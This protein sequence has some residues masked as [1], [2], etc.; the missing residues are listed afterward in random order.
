MVVTPETWSSFLTVSPDPLLCAQRGPSI[1][2]YCLY[3]L[4][5]MPWLPSAPHCSASELLL[6]CPHTIPTPHQLWFPILLDPQRSLS[7]FHWCFAI[8]GSSASCAF[9]DCTAHLKRESFLLVSI[10]VG[11][12]KLLS[13]L[14][15]HKTW[16]HCQQI[17]VCLYPLWLSSSLPC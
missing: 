6:W 4:Q 1:S 17:L 13:R 3:V 10:P 8:V 5:F 14:E 2:S 16:P 9:P 15:V 12:I 11:E 7:T